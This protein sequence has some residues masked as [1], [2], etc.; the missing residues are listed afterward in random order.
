MW[1]KL[2]R[3]A[4]SHPYR[5]ERVP[6]GSPTSN[7]IFVFLLGVESEA[8]AGSAMRLGQTKEPITGILAWQIG[9]ALASC[10]GGLTH[11]V[12]LVAVGRGVVY[13]GAY[14]MPGGRLS[15]R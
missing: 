11:C 6:L 1:Q 8:E 15:A 7:S 4:W 10:K 13:V 3:G 5:L 12:C 14:P 9:C 2:A